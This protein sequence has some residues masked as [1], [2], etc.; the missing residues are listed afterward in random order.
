MAGGDASPHSSDNDANERPV[1]EKLRE[2]SIANS[3]QEIDQVLQGHCGTTNKSV[4]NNDLKTTS[5]SASQRDE[6]RGRLGRK[7]SFDEVEQNASVDNNDILKSDSRKRSRESQEQRSV[8]PDQGSKNGL[9]HVLD[10]KGAL[11]GPGHVTSGARDIRTT[12]QSPHGQ[13]IGNDEDLTLDGSV[14]SPRRKRSREQVD[15]DAQREQKIVATEEARASRQSDEIQRSDDRS[16]GSGLALDPTL[17]KTATSGCNHGLAEAASGIPGSAR[18]K[19]HSINDIEQTKTEVDEEPVD[20]PKATPTSS[21]TTDPFQKSGL[22]AFSQSTTSGFGALGS[23]GSS[24]ANRS[25]FSSTTADSKGEATDDNASAG[26]R[27]DFAG[28]VE[29]HKPSPFAAVSSQPAMKASPFGTT[30]F[31]GFGVGGGF[32]KGP[33]IRSFAARNGDVDLQGAKYKVEVF[34]APE[35][36]DG[37]DNNSE[38]GEG[39]S[40]G[41]VSGD[42]PVNNT[43]KFQHREGECLVPGVYP[44]MTNIVQSIPVKKAKN[45]SIITVD[46]VCTALAKG[47]GE[48]AERVFSKSMSSSKGMTILVMLPGINP[49]DLS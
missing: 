2:T 11:S 23:P 16:Q 17:A 49:Q 13:R 7:R 19:S 31:G 1:R 47:R 21:T 24:N 46:L 15:T 33:S 43:G 40:E 27:H 39:N 34:G 20:H 32:G 12:E 6:L 38:S 22:A 18:Q 10:D 5:P 14:F 44:M 25:I 4:N 3:A 42:E 30:V 35:K 28:G 26:L 37:D 8:D 45:P 36:G 41:S 9:D 29:I 48:N